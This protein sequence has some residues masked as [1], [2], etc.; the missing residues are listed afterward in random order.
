MTM[1]QIWIK[2]PRNEHLQRQY[3]IL[4]IQRLTKFFEPSN[5]IRTLRLPLTR[6]L[7]LSPVP[8]LRLS[9]FILLLLTQ[10]IISQSLLHL[11]FIIISSINCIIRL[12]WCKLAIY[13]GLVGAFLWCGTGGEELDFELF[14]LVGGVLGLVLGEGKELVGGMEG[15]GR[16]NC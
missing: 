10:P 1:A 4:A 15:Q 6:T 8:L 11:N 2:G 5:T 9:T 12:S 16:T 3:M 7:N 14:W 13:V